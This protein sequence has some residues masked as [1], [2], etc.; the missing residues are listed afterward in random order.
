MNNTL[1]EKGHDAL[2]H[3]TYYLMPSDSRDAEETSGVP[4]NLQGKRA[5]VVE[6][7]G[8]TQ[9][10]LK[11]VLQ[12]QGVEIVGVASNGAEA[13]EVVLTTRPDFVLMDI[14]MPIMNGLDAAER[15]LAEYHVCIVMLTAYSEQE[16]Q[17]RAQE[18]GACGYS[19][20]PITAASLIPTIQHALQRFS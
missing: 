17:R 4:V 19:L 12:R 3:T 11:K 6:D 9:M 2:E 13:V 14:H 15:I 16:Y 10:Q 8:L 1:F 7:Q 20:K 5:V 18:L